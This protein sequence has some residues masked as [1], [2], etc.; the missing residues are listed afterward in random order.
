MGKPERGVIGVFSGVAAGIS[1]T[2]IKTGGC[3]RLRVRIL[4]TGYS[5]QHGK[6]TRNRSTQM[7]IQLQGGVMFG[8]FNGK[9]LNFLNRHR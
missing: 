7:E 3:A 9:S 5:T 4:R 6:K 1:D 2:A 8:V